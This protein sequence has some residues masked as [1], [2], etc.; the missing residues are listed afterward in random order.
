MNSYL[1]G[2]FEADGHIDFIKNKNPRFCIRTHEKNKYWLLKVKKTFGNY[3]FIRVKKRERALVLTIS[4]KAG[5]KLVISLL[6]GHLKT[7][8]IIVFNKLISWMNEAQSENSQYVQQIKYYD[9]DYNLENSWLSGFIDGDGGFYVRYT[10]GKKSINRKERIGCRMTL[11]QRVSLKCGTSY[12]KIMCC[13]KEKLNCKLYKIEKNSRFY[14][15]ISCSSMLEVTNLVEYLDSY[16]LKSSKYLDYVDFKE[17]HL[18]L[19]SKIAYENV[20]LV[21]LYKLRM[22]NSRN[23]EDIVWNHL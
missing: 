20:T 19:K 14:Y 5:L 8:K 2:V 16:E 4:N 10:K 13:I 21:K 23:Y 15:I 22:N 6:N 3:G 9:I 12:D 17:V 7:P 11:Y 18:M 1:A